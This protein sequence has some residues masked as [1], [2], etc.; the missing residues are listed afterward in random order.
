MNNYSHFFTPDRI[1]FFSPL[2]SKYRE[3]IFGCLR[4]LYYRLYSPDADFAYQVTR[5][6]LR[7]LFVQVIRET[8]V[9]SDEDD[10][11]ELFRHDAN[12]QTKANAILKKLITSGWLENYVDKG[13]MLSTYRFT[14]AG[15][16]FSESIAWF[17]KKGLQTRQRNV[18]NTK[19]ALQAFLNDGDPFD[20]I[21]AVDYAKR[22]T[23][24]LSDEIAALHERKQALMKTAIQKAQIA[25]QELLDY[26]DNHFRHDLAIRFSADSIVRH[27]NQIREIIEKIKSWAPQKLEQAEARLKALVS[28]KEYQDSVP[29]TYQLLY[30]IERYLESAERVKMPELRDALESYVGRTTLIIKQATAMLA[31]LKEEELAKALQTLG[32]L[33]PGQ[34]N[35]QLALIGQHFGNMSVR[36]VAPNTIRLRQRKQREI[37]ADIQAT[38]PPTREELLQAALAEAE[39]NAFTISLDDIRQEIIKQMGDESEMRVSHL[40]VKDAATFLA[41]SH[42]IEVGSISLEK[43]KPCLLVEPIEDCFQNGYIEAKDY[44][45]R[46]AV[47]TQ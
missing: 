23:S 44:I 13:A 12:D 46:K 40:N 7:D 30:Q 1:K 36:L 3:V 28:E 41:L 6:E 27:H 4:T 9:F 21:D 14:R 37:S 22:V 19:N 35:K 45:I 8:P 20:L 31:G 25:I 10:K 15:K 32:T 5:E 38:Q 18:R 17:D 24:D 33:S 26:M 16:A 43:E 47:S 29:I 11:E 39:E 42:A 2:N 34:Q